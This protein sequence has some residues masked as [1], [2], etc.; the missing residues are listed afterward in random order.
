MSRDARGRFLPDNTV[1]RLPLSEA[2]KQSVVLT[3]RVTG[4]LAERAYAAAAR[5]Q[6]PLS[7]LIRT[8][9]WRLSNDADAPSA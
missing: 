6:T 2:D 5:R 8:Y 7:V 9:L 4:E 1:R 3:V